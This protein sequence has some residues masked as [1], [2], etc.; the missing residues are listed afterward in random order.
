MEDK[1]RGCRGGLVGALYAFFPDRLALTEF[2]DKK[3]SVSDA[4]GNQPGRREINP[5]RPDPKP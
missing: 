1:G 4:A 2:L 3:D 5:P